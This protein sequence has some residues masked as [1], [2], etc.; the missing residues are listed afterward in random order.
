MSENKIIEIE[1]DY[2]KENL[3]INPT[4]TPLSNGEIFS[5]YIA[6]KANMSDE[7]RKSLESGSTTILGKCINPKNIA[8]VNLNSTGLCFGQIQSGKTTSME[9][10]FTLAA[11]NNFKILIL[12]T[13]SVGPLVV[14][15]TGR[16]DNILESRRFEVLRNV[17]REWDHPRIL[18]IL[19]EF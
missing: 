11:D 17:G 16:I 3:E 13:G 7:D 19:K 15:N 18:D 8:E 1:Q 4:W 10:V 14:Q 6:A 12:L 2:S 5:N 9:A